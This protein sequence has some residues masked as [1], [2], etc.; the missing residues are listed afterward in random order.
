MDPAPDDSWSV[1]ANVGDPA[2]DEL[3]QTWYQEYQELYMVRLSELFDFEAY[4]CGPQD[5][6][7]KGLS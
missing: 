5:E 4:A 1:D 6:E 2:V 7:G 3:P